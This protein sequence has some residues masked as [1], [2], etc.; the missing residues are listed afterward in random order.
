MKYM[1]N[2][3]NFIKSLTTESSMSLVESILDGYRT[4]FENITYPNGFELREFENMN[5]FTARKRYADQ[6]LEKI[7]TGSAR[8]V[9]AIDDAH[10]L[11]LAKNKKGVAQNGVETDGYLQQN[12]STILASVVESH[13][14]DLWI[15]SERAKKI[16]KSK[17]KQLTGYSFDDFAS[18]LRDRVYEIEG[19]R[20]YIGS[21]KGKED[22]LDDE[23]FN[24][25]V[26][27]TVS[28]DME[29]GDFTRISSYGEIEND[30]VVIDT[31]LTKEVYKE[32]YGR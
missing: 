22:I 1:Y 20:G 11:K 31:G 26:D 16:N 19:R 25:I 12:Y 10:V 6:H 30:P 21:Y 2:I 9:Y 15:I 14:D 18:V 28:M 5:N 4:I 29:V 32:H 24:E 8:I 27:M 23:F 13:P 7:G 17:F 3:K